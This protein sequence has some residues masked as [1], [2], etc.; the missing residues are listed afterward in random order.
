M[1][2]TSLGD[3]NVTT[4]DVQEVVRRIVEVAQPEKIILF[5]SAARGEMEPH[6][7]LDILVVKSGADHWS[8]SGRIRRA[9]RG[10]NA[11]VDL[12]VATP[13]NIERY[14]DSHPLVYKPALR[15]GRVVYDAA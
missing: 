10:V 13:E 11:A 12:V 7:D 6:S 4:S 5:G 2:R 3:T 14:K 1:N 8:L 15:E 9:L